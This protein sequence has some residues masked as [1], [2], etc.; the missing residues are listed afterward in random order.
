MQHKKSPTAD[1]LAQLKTGIAAALPDLAKK[2]IELPKIDDKLQIPQAKSCPYCNNTGYRGR[3]GIYEAFL[4]DNEMQRF[5][6]SNTS[7][8]DLKELARKKGML[9]M[10]QD[11]LIK[12]LEGITTLEEVKRTAEA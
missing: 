8:V 4:V 3:I 10:Y 12:V 6:Q 9:T 1:E 5:I 2:G 7:I 11:G